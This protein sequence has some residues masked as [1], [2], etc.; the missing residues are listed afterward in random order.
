MALDQAPEGNLVPLLCQ[1]DELTIFF[2]L[3]PPGLLVGRIRGGAIHE[4]PGPGAQVWAVLARRE[5]Q[6]LAWQ[7]V[8]RLQPRRLVRVRGGGR[9]RVKLTATVQGWGRDSA[10]KA[11]Q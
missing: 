7:V 5:G 9:H 1:P 2:R 6:P 11:V 4:A 3:L 8:L 10:R